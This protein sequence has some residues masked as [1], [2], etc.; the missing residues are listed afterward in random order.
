MHPVDLI[1][2]DFAGGRLAFK[3]DENG[4]ALAY[5]FRRDRDRLPADEVGTARVKA[6]LHEPALLVFER[7][8]VVAEELHAGDL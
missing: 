3:A 8:D 6:E 1:R 5:H 2:P 4:H 7:P